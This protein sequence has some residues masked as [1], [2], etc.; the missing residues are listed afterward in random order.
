MIGPITADRIQRAVEAYQMLL[1][2]EIPLHHAD[3]IWADICDA[4]DL[5]PPSV[6]RDAL[7]EALGVLTDA[8]V[9]RAYDT[10]V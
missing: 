5:M 8:I 2:G 3:R 10:E 4:W 9:S 6:E 1:A 7:G